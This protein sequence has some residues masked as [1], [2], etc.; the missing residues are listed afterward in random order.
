M[1]ESMVK[2]SAK[3]VRELLVPLPGREEQARVLRIIETLSRRIREEES[4]GQK[5][6]QLKKGLMH[7]LLTGKV[8]VPIHED[9][10]D[11]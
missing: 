8:R 4:V 11:E 2:I 3:T 7:D 9:D 10:D 5:A 6:R 1:T